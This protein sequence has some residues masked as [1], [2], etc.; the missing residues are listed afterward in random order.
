MQNLNARFEGRTV[1]FLFDP[2]GPSKDLQVRDTSTGQVLLEMEINNGNV[3]TVAAGIIR[4]AGRAFDVDDDEAAT[5]FAE[6]IRSEVLGVSL[7]AM[8]CVCGQRNPAGSVFC[9][10]CGNALGSLSDS[11]TRESIKTVTKTFT[12]PI[13]GSPFYRA[14]E[15]TF[16]VAELCA[17]MA[18][19]GW[20]Y[21]DSHM[22]SVGRTVSVTFAGPSPRQQLSE[23]VGL[24]DIQH[25]GASTFNPFNALAPAQKQ[26]QE[27]Q[28]AAKAKGWIVW[29]RFQF[30]YNGARAVLIG[31]ERPRPPSNQSE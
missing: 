7:D 30:S 21:E 9:N 26:A 1:E 17:H 19:D 31:Y 12:I 3:P 23:Q 15:Y 5:K 13:L 11:Q 10:A 25:F 27:W 14:K 2:S 8:S 16:G 28:R 4:L 29:F 18:R 6:A 20:V 24:V 22:P